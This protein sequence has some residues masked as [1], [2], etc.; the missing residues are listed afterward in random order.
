ML[1]MRRSALRLSWRAILR[2]PSLRQVRL[3]AGLVLF[4]YVTTHFINHALGNISVAA[5][6]NGLVVQK[7]IWQTPP[8]A[9]LL[10]ASMAVHMGLGFWVLYERRHFRWTRLEATQLILGVS[11][12]FSSRRPCARHARFAEPVR[13]AKGLCRGAAEILGSRPGPRRAAGAA[14]ARRVDP[15][16]RRHLFLAPPEVLLSPPAQHPAVDRGAAAGA[17]AARLLPGRRDRAG[18]GGR[19][20]LAGAAR[21]AGPRRHGAAERLADQLSHVVFRRAGRDARC[22]SAGAL[23]AKL[24]RAPP[25]PGAADL[26][27]AVGAGA[28]RP[29]RAR[30]EPA[31]WHSP[32][33]CLRR[34]RALLDLPHPRHRRARR[35]PA[36]QRRRA[37]GAGAGAGGNR[38]P[39]RLP[40]AARA[41]HLLRSAA[42]AAGRRRQRL[43]GSSAPFRRR[44]LRRHPV[45]RHARLDRPGRAPAAVRHGVS[46]Q[47]VSPCGEQRGDR[48]R[49]NPQPDCRRRPAGA[50]RRRGRARRSLPPGGR[51]ERPD[52]RQCRAAQR[53]DDQRIA[54]ADPF[55][56]RHPRRRR[57]PRR[58]RL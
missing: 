7:W 23:D 24:A 9:I 49:R 48:R 17:G 6:E 33:A 45:R 8:G 15:R 43:Q 38:R 16:L 12:P 14:A 35:A 47:P 52:R 30:G 26:S 58:H 20:G 55:R 39:A 46:D 4:A 37:G 50:V 28:A 11:I 32:R 57:D 22:D 42:V 19:S 44:A 13:H 5:M 21:D 40:I 25:R 18:A 10:Y 1:R 56:H 54:G 36:R 2:R 41:R 34:P 27:R 3:A 31:L 29:Q 53:A 51:G